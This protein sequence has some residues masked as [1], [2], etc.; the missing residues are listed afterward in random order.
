MSTLPLAHF[1]ERLCRSQLLE[2]DR[3]KELRS[4]QTESAGAR[5]LAQEL[6][7]REWLTPY[8]ISQLMQDRQ[9]DLVLGQYILLEPLGE[10]GMG[11]VFKAYQRN[12]HRLVALKVIRRDCLDNPKVIKRFQ[13]EIR[14]AGQ[15]SHPNV[16]RA[17]DADEV[18]GIY[19]IAMELV[20]GIDLAHLVKEAGPLPVA[21]ACDYVCQAALGL[22]HA[23]ECGMVHRDIKPANLLVTHASPSAKRESAT[24]P[25]PGSGVPAKPSS[26]ALK[27]PG[28]GVLQRPGTADPWGTV[29]ILDMGLARLS[30]SDPGVGAGNLTQ[31]GTLMG[32]PDFIAPEQ[33]VNSRTCDIRAD[34]YSLGC[35][36]YY[37]LSGQVP[38]PE[39]TTL[40]KVIRHQKEDPAPVE[41]ARR[42]RL[43]CD[44]RTEADADRYYVPGEVKAV[45]AK[46]LAKHP[47]D[48]FQTPGEVAEA[49]ADVLERLA[50]GVPGPVK[51]EGKT[52]IESKPNVPYAVPSAAV[53][54]PEACTAQRTHV[55]RYAVPRLSRLPRKWVTLATVVGALGIGMILAQI[56]A[57][58]RPRAN[59]PAE[60]AWLKT[61]PLEQVLWKKLTG[62]VNKRT[63]DLNELRQDLVR[64]RVQ[65]FNTPQA[66]EVPALL[67][68]LP[69]VFDALER[70]N[71]D[72]KQ[73]FDWQPKEVVGVLGNWPMPGD[74][75][76]PEPRYHH[77][78][79]V[80]P[81]GRYVVSGGPN[82]LLR[83]WDLAT[84]LEYKVVGHAK[85]V[86]RI[87]FAPDGATFATASFDG[88]TKLWDTKSRNLM[89]TLDTQEREVAAGRL[90]LMSSVA[91]KPD[92]SLLASAGADGV[93]RFWDLSTRPP[94]PK[95]ALDATLGNVTALTFS[96]DGDHVFWAEEGGLVRWALL[97]AGKF[98]KAHQLRAGPGMIKALELSSDG[99]ALVLSAGK[100][101]RLYS[102]NG[103]VLSETKV[104][105]EHSGFVHAVAFA[106][107]GKTFA[108]VAEDKTVKLW[109]RVTGNPTQS[110][111]LRFP[112]V[113][114]A[115]T[116][117]GRHFLTA[118]SNSTVY[119]FRP[120]ARLA[121]AIATQ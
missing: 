87:A 112:V 12:L 64:F 47:Q 79:A 39:G 25:R 93:I 75:K 61:E 70:K 58:G 62:K 31:A 77:A 41:K 2:A 30:D 109:D 26:A 91:Y 3:L 106:P 67:A 107:D 13:R 7:R 23:H 69:S 1:V 10:G 110:W 52:A 96:A 85:Q 38:F 46:M 119:V 116:P 37:L 45:L 51:H 98:D 17:Y 57:Q 117:E 8:Q 105:H 72:K 18:G 71:I 11:Q 104:A 88:T 14:A 36:L 89:A 84:N 108:T 40:D 55:S 27:R 97:S 59:P 49:M 101:V 6:M 115:F 113:N 56:G 60:D 74:L 42:A 103:V 16:V 121:D 80:S 44:D 111:E 63:T 28:S 34:I 86:V 99:Q 43:M 82:G 114:V 65:Y 32:T 21:Q 22:Q 95:K 20:D 102:W 5:D 35:T 94:Q 24:V 66:R 50:G 76:K 9:G 120:G 19:Y 4:L 54:P 29:K 53:T 118:N 48:R 100:D 33:A 78:L 73:W 83:T 15:L 68:L 92:G 81:D 90:K